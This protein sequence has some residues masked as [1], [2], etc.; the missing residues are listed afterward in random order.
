[1]PTNILDATIGI[2]TV[3]DTPISYGLPHARPLAQNTPRDAGLEEL[4]AP[5]N[6][7]SKMENLLCPHVGDGECLRPEIFFPQ[8]ESCVAALRQMKANDPHDMP[9]EGRVLLDKEL[10]PLL[11]NRQL[12]QSYMGLMIG[13]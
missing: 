7:R 1:M 8:L 11:E 9:A 4:Y 12:L 13:G 6:L 3:M 10:V 5:V 2:Q